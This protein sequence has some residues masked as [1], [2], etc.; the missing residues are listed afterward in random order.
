MTLHFFIFSLLFC[1]SPRRCLA[2]C[3]LLKLLLSWYPIP[4]ITMTYTHF[5]F[6]SNQQYPPYCYEGLFKIEAIHDLWDLACCGLKICSCCSYY[7]SPVVTSLC[8]FGKNMADYQICFFSCSGSLHRVRL[9]LKLCIEI[10]VSWKS[11]GQLCNLLL[12]LFIF[13][14]CQWICSPLAYLCQ[15]SLSGT[16][17]SH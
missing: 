16:I 1:F 11:F 7:R 4:L 8:H 2:R 13:Q 5:C 15:W 3:F 6:S 14:T 12:C 9:W 10:D 17:W